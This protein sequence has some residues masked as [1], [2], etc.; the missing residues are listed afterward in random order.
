MATRIQGT[1]A[2]ATSATP[3]DVPMKQASLAPV[4]SGGSLVRVFVGDFVRD[5]PSLLS[6]IV[7]APMLA[8]QGRNSIALVIYT[9]FS[10]FCHQIPER[11]FEIAGHPLA[12]C[13]RCTGIYFGF[14]AGV[15]VY[16][17]VRSLKR[18]DAPARLLAQRTGGQRKAAKLVQGEAL[19]ERR[20]G[21]VR[22]R[23][24]GEDVGLHQASSKILFGV[25]CRHSPGPSGPTR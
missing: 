17:L 16:P 6:L 3:T 24:D 1:P 8:A 10:K 21:G 20:H 7:I 22:E 15:L 9:A 12:V 4:S 11:S 13:A 14:A 25:R 5:W 23:P 18:T 2:R 19:V